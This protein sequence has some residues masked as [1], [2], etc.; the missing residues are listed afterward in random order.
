MEVI[1]KEDVPNLGYKDDIVNV[2]DGYARNYLIPQGKAYIATESAKKMLAEKQK[3]RAH[4]LEQLKAEAQ[5]MADKMRD[6]SLTIG[7]KTSSTGTIFGSVTN[8]Q[9][10]DALKEKGFEIDRKI[11]AIKEPVKEI[12]NYIAIVKLHKEIT[13]EI[14]FEVISE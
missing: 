1:L 7:A 6:V 9:I 14:P 12:G 8:I 4:K 3:Q 5:D 13:V 10:A 2:K 11:I